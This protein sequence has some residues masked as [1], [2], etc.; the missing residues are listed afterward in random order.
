[1]KVQQNKSQ[2]FIRVFVHVSY[3]NIMFTINKLLSTRNICYYTAV[4]L[5]LLLVASSVE[6]A[7]YADCDCYYFGVETRVCP[8]STFQF[9][10]QNKHGYCE[11]K[12][13]DPVTGKCKC[14]NCDSCYLV[15][16]IEA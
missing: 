7:R 13:N 10:H 11:S 1:M 15:N 2:R 3:Y 16:Q 12:G 4:L 6:G 5:A 8:G 9:E 14:Y